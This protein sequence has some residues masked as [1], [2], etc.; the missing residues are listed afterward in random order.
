MKKFSSVLFVCLLLAISAQTFAQRIGFQAG[1]N[2]AKMS[3]KDDDGDYNDVIDAL[4]GFNAGV[5]LEIPFGDLF[6][7]EAALIAETKGY[8]I[9]GG[10]LFDDFKANALFIDLPILVKVGPSFGPIKVF[11]AAGP[12]IG[13]GVAGKFKS[14]GDS[15]DIEWGDGADADSK[16]MDF[17]AKF[18]IGAEFSGL[19]LGVYYALG[20]ANMAPDDDDNTKNFSRTLSISVGYKFGGK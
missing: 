12:F 2:F 1:V 6:S 19:N 7:V 17:G 14:G 8:K 3:V 13:M 11:G 9:D 16:R 20:L 18:G 10:L 5:N 15:E 4:M